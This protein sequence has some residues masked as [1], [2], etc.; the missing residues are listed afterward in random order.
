M[1][2]GPALPAERVQPP[3]AGADAGSPRGGGHR[4][5]AA[6]TKLHLGRYR[7]LRQTART[8]VSIH[9]IILKLL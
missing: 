5:P 4:A 8:Q 7:A 6:S 9:I 3:E 1:S 2:I